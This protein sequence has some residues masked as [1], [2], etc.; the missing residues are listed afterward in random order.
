MFNFGVDLGG[1]NISAGIVDKNNNIIFKESVKTGTSQ[2]TDDILK[3]IV[4]LYYSIINKA[5]IN[6]TLI[7]NVGIGVPG[8]INYDTFIIEHCPNLFIKNWN[9]ISSL[10]SKI[11]KPL[12]IDNDAN[13]ALLAEQFFIKNKENLTI[14]MITI[15]TGIGSSIM[16]HNK[17]LNNCELGHMII[18]KNGRPCNCGQNGCFETY[19]SITGLKTTTK[20]FLKNNPDSLINKL[21]NYD[22]NNLSGKTVFEALK[23]N[24]LAAKKILNTYIDD[25]SCGISNLI[26]IFN[27]DFLIIGGGISKEINHLINPIKNHFKKKNIKIIPAKFF[28]DSGIIGAAALADRPENR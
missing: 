13:C 3:K 11:N 4:D 1:T 21:I 20:E 23:F 19:A 27:P 26:N 25:L 5:N 14:A 15:G 9:I 10:K 22:I 6:E 8:K 12:Y 28:N 24:D 17:I 2:K 18:N 16:I 7:E